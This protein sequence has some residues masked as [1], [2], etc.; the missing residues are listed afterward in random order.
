MLPETSANGN[1]TNH[2]PPVGTEPRYDRAA[3][4]QSLL[5]ALVLLRFDEQ[6]RMELQSTK[7]ERKAQLSQ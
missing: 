7:F 5:S 1:A 4:L 6:I 3:L 2:C